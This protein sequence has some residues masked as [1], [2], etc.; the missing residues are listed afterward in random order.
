M[1]RLQVVAR[2]L[3][4]QPSEF[5]ILSLQRDWEHRNK[6]TEESMC[7]LSAIL[8]AADIDLCMVF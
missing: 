1:L 6:W 8:S 3:T 7:I 2:F 4:A 5:I